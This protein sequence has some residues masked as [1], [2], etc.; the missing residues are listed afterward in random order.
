V[1]WKILFAI[2]RP[3]WGKLAILNTEDIEICGRITKIR[4]DKNAICLHLLPYVL[5]ICRKFAF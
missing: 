3:L 1:T 2:S 5:N 4:G